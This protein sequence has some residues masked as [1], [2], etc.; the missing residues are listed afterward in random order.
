[1]LSFVVRQEAGMRRVLGWG[2]D[3]RMRIHCRTAGLL[4]VARAG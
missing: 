1:M 3:R 4:T 2:T